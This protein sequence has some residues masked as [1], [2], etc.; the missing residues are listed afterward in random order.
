[1]KNK[2]Y[3]FNFTFLIL[4]GCVSQEKLIKNISCEGNIVLQYD[5]IKRN[6][7]GKPLAN[8]NLNAFNVYFIGDFN[9][10]IQSYVNNKLYFENFLQTNNNSDKITNGFGYNYSKDSK[11]PV[12]KIISKSK[13]TCFD[14]EVNKKYKLIYV[15]ISNEGK[16]T[17]R[18]SN[19]Y[20]FR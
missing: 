20:Y 4:F 13:K 1:M 2:I 5:K 15:F 17:V 11:I 16:W 19:I 3:I 18:F 10:S 7:L 6:D 12:L 9:D 14:L 8:K